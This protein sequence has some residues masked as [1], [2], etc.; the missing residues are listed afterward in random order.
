MKPGKIAKRG[1]LVHAE[2]YGGME[3]MGNSKE[4]FIGKGAGVAI[5]AYGEP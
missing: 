3:R 5:I 4:H 2:F 1:I